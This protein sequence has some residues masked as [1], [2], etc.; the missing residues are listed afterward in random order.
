MSVRSSSGRGSRA[1]QAHARLG[2]LPDGAPGAR[3]GAAVAG[4]PG[5][6]RGLGEPVVD[7]L[8]E[9]RALVFERNG[10]AVLAPLE[11]DVM[12]WADGFVEHRGRSLGVESELG[13]SW[14]AQLVLG[15]LPERVQ[16]P[17]ARAELMFAPAESLPFGDRPLAERALPA[18]RAGAEDRAPADPGRRP[19]RAGG[20]RRRAGRLRSR[21]RAHAGGE[22]PARLP[23]GVEPPAAAARDAGD[24][25]RR[26]P[27]RSELEQR[28]EMCRRAYGEV[29]LH[30]PLGDQL[31]LFLQHLPGQRTRLAGYDDTLTTEQVAAMMPTATHAAGSRRGF[32][33]GHTLSG[34]RQPVTLQ[35]PRGLG[36]RPQHDDPQR[37]RARIGQDDARPEAQVRGVPAGRAGD[38]L[39]PE[40]RPPLSPARGGR[41]ARRVRHAAARPGAAGHARPAAGRA[42]APAPGR[43]GLVPARPAA[44]AGRAGMGDGGRRS[45][46]PRHHALRESPPAS[47]SCSALERGRRDRRA[48]RQ[49][50]R[51]LRPLRADPARVRRPRCEAAGGRAPPGHL[52][53]DPRPA[54]P[55]ARGH[56]TVGVLPGRAG[57][58]ADRAAD[59]D[60]RDAPDGRRARAAEAV[61]LRRGL[62]AARATRSA[63]RCSARCSAWAARSWPCRSSARSSSPTRW[64]AS[65]SRSRT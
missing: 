57:R 6:C 22:G 4:P 35:P 13:T 16:F 10:E 42:R 27:T 9:P 19:D 56:A 32:Y 17:G 64:S 53:A 24:R 49:G 14:Q 31:Q 33:L 8:H 65:A 2:G 26:P 11:G 47:R 55:R 52:P 41:A 62:A 28:V 54:R 51:G 38:R 1:D 20:V 29:R 12:R 43:R 40:G 15:A 34:S 18:Q 37:R 50:A 48:G 21:L 45:G 3:R 23:A 59:R 46:R 36:Q 30:R 5:F 44:G 60:V 61:L 7:G 39:R 25:G 58:R 63:G